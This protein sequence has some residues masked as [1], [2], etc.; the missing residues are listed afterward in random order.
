MR[1]K[2]AFWGGAEHFRA[3]FRFDGPSTCDLVS[4]TAG[5]ARTPRR[6]RVGR[7]RMTKAELVAAIAQKSGLTKNQSKEALDAFVD[8]VTAALKEGPE[9][10]I[11]GFGSFLPVNRPAGMA[12]NPRT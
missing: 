8:C 2:N 1:S 12:R 5:A 11:V 9:V 3:A 4:P 10:R 6:D 7:S